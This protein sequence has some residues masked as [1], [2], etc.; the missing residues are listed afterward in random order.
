[1]VRMGREADDVVSVMRADGDIRTGVSSPKRYL[2]ADDS[3]WLE[4]AN[5]HMADTADRCRTGAYAATLQGPLLRYIHEDDRDFL[6]EDEEPQENQYAAETPTKPRHAPRAMMT[7]A[8]YELLCQ[9]YSFVNSPAYRNK[10]GEAGRT[11]EIR[12]LTLSYPTR[13]IQAERDRLAAQGTRR[14]RSSPARWARTSASGR[15]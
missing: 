6:L 11:R 3:S 15:S 7:A 1:M 12:T 9:A 2:W 13:M 4:G 10:S 14:S 5:W 8:L